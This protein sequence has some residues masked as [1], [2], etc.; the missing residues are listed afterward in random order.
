MKQETPRKGRDLIPGEKIYSV[1]TPVPNMGQLLRKDAYPYLFMMDLK[2]FLGVHP[3]APNGVLTFYDSRNNAIKAKNLVKGRGLAV[4][5]NVCEFT[6]AKDGVPE[7]SEE[8]AK[9]ESDL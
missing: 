3:H 7:F 9:H 1:A 2:G 4:G 8:R 6:V 5:R